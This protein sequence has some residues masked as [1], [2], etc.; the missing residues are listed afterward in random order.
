MDKGDRRLSFL[1]CVVMS[2]FIVSIIALGNITVFAEVAVPG[3]G[4]SSIPINLTTEANSS[5]LHKVI[6]KRDKNTNPERWVV[7]TS[8][9]E[10]C[11]LKWDS[12]QQELHCSFGSFQLQIDTYSEDG[13]LEESR[14][15]TGY[16][17]IQGTIQ[18]DS[19]IKYTNRDMLDVNG[20]LFLSKSSTQPVS[21]IINIKLDEKPQEQIDGFPQMFY[22]DSLTYDTLT[23]NLTINMKQCANADM[24]FGETEL[25]K[26]S[27]S[28]FI[29]ISNNLD[30]T[31]KR[32]VGSTE[33]YFQIVGTLK[34]GNTTF[35]V[36]I[37]GFGRKVFHRSFTEL[38][39]YVN[40][41]GEISPDHS[42]RPADSFVTTLSH[43]NH[44]MVND[45]PAISYHATPSTI[46]DLSTNTSLIHDNIPTIDRI[47]SNA[48]AIRVNG[49]TPCILLDD[50]PDDISYIVHNN[51]GSTNSNPKFYYYDKD[52]NLVSATPPNTY[53]AIGYNYYVFS[54]DI[55]S[56]KQSNTGRY[57]PLMLYS[58]YD[59]YTTVPYIFDD[60]SSTN[61]YDNYIDEVKQ[62]ANSTP[63]KE[64]DDNFRY[65]WNLQEQSKTNDFSGTLEINTELINDFRNVI[66]LEST[67]EAKAVNA[68][69]KGIKQ[70][71]MNTEIVEMYVYDVAFYIEN[72]GSYSLNFRALENGSI[73]SEYPITVLYSPNLQIDTSLADPPANE[74]VI[75]TDSNYFIL[76]AKTTQKSLFKKAKE[77]RIKD[78]NGN[79]LRE[80]PTFFKHESTTVN[81]DYNKPYYTDIFKFKKVSIHATYAKFEIEYEDDDNNTVILES[82]NLID[83]S[84]NA[85]GD[86]TTG[87]EII[88]TAENI[89]DEVSKIEVLKVAQ[90]KME[91]TTIGQKAKDFFGDNWLLI[92]FVILVVILI[93]LK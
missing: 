81:M 74:L 35:G 56:I 50:M 40:T 11:D 48:I 7:V 26:Y 73:I 89:V 33:P 38:Y 39:N 66:V 79:I 69:Y 15:S 28:D 57:T 80:F 72:E 16:W 32:Y 20:D 36:D 17:D 84:G 3:G 1:L 14:T 82:T 34:E 24:V 64:I 18:G 47:G 68:S 12:S 51:S 42:G 21:N 44:L 5:N 22:A 63:I 23:R 76:T 2:I 29:V 19:S 27:T 10:A 41:D 87:G 83:A 55:S 58:H 59:N 93:I 88:E 13:S 53:R 25:I 31:T 77:I 43:V 45:H 54:M 92:V 90:D 91:E 8:L 9:N 70:Y 78:M 60:Y 46:E 37:Y 61:Q 75:T 30:I 65:L 85:W 86:P 67:G 4:G 71:V 6:Y 52:G 62:F 49:K